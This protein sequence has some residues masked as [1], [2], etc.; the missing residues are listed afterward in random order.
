MADPGFPSPV[1]LGVRGV[2]ACADVRASLAGQRMF[3]QGGTAADAAVA[4][5][6]VL[7][8]TS[9]HSCGLGGDALAMVTA[10][11]TG[12]VAL[13]GVGRAGSGADAARLRAEGHDRMPLRHDVRAVTVPAAVDAWLALHQRFGRLPWARVL[14]PA[15]ELATDGFAAAGLLVPA[16]TLVAGLPGSEELCPAGPLRAGQQVRLPGIARVLGA[17]TRQGREGFYQGEAG[18]AL[19]DL[20]PGTLEPRDLAHPLADWAEPLRLRVWGHDLWTVPPPSQ[21][22]LTLAGAWIA[23]AAG[24]PADASSDR[25]AHLVV[26]AARAAGHDRPEVLHEGAD[27]AALLAE[28]RLGSAAARVDPEHRAPPDVPKRFD[29][30][31]GAPG[32]DGDTTHLCA[33]DGEGLGVSLTQSNALDFGTHLVAGST[34]IFLHNRG[35]GFSLDPGHPAELAPGR[36]P[37]HTLSPTLVTRSD[38]SLAHLVGTMGGDGQPQILLQVLARLLL[39]GED[40]AAAVAGPRLILDAPRA[41]PFRLWFGDDLM[42]RVEARAPKAWREGLERRGHRVATLDPAN[43]ASVGFAQAI[44]VGP[45]PGPDGGRFL[46]GAADPRCAEGGALGT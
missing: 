20:A 37:P 2:I 23:G 8:V 1:R 25:W 18:R 36:R 27:G 19:L 14:E 12:P 16:S 44:S 24:L 30:T 9:P 34:G 21:G 46:A 28:D 31:T 40:V 6:A 11:R 43:E 3:D 22:Y 42:V 35:L 4:A 15:T 29:V 39:S 5:A 7:A 10:P 41:G 26:E 38:G 45:A 32:P 13:L 17:L 33:L